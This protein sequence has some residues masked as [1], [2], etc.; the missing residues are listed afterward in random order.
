MMFQF[1]KDKVLEALYRLE[2]DVTDEIESLADWM[3][4]AYKQLSSKRT[5]IRRF[6]W[7]LEGM[8]EDCLGVY[9]SE[10]D[11]TMLEDYL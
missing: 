11:Y 2:E 6:C 4:E 5:L 8:T 7:I 3:G 10:E 1:P 9:L